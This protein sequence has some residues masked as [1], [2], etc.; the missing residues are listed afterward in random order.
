MGKGV[1]A[2]EKREQKVERVEQVLNG[3]VEESVKK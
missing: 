1:T 2:K 3:K